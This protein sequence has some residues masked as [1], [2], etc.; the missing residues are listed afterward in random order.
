MIRKHIFW[1]SVYVLSG[2]FLFFL[3]FFDCTLPDG[4]L[5]V[6]FLNVGQGDAILIT[7][8]KG[9]HILVDGGPVSNIMQVLPSKLPYFST[10]IDLIILTHSHSDHLDGLFDVMKRYEVGAVLLPNTDKQNEE[11]ASFLKNIDD[12]KKI[13]ARSD[14]DFEIEK[15]IFMDVLFPTREKIISDDLNDTSVVFRLSYGK[16]NFFFTGDMSSLLEK[17]ILLT[18]DDVRSDIL[19]ISHHGSK[20]SSSTWF[21]KAVSP[22]TAVISVAK[23]NTFNHPGISTLNTL[24]TQDVQVYRTDEGGTIDFSCGSTD[25]CAISWEKEPK[26]WGGES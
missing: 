20:Y 21:V 7:T 4:K 16:T 10:T 3:L 5:H 26:V 18:G 17:K 1:G 14:H 2:V 24:K 12:D 25:D 19:K 15:G 11:Y 6:S 9:K 13:M 23:K 8:P 22:E